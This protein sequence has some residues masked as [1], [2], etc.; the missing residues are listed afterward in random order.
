MGMCEVYPLVLLEPKLATLSF[1]ERLGLFCIVAVAD[2]K[3]RFLW[4]A[5]KL[6]QD[7]FPNDDRPQGISLMVRA[8]VAAKREGMLR[9][10]E[11]G[12]LLY[13]EVVLPVLI[14]SNKRQG[15]RRRRRASRLPAPHSREEEEARPAPSRIASRRALFALWWGG[16]PYKDHSKKAEEV[17]NLLLDSG[18]SVP[19]LER[20]LHAYKMSCYARIR[21]GEELARIGGLSFLE[22]AWVSY[23]PE[24]DGH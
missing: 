18:V 5:S 15:W 10:Y 17:F 14:R 23:E 4:S 22:E 8:L 20:A 19:R 24:T 3:G 21:T 13:G 6:A 16:Y 11:V 2:P 9:Q 12:S 1:E 7:A